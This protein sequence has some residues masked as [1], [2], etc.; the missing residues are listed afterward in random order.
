M[1]FHKE[2]QTEGD[3]EKGALNWSI[4]GLGW[5]EGVNT[6]CEILEGS[7]QNPADE[8][9]QNAEEEMI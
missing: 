1:G 2:R 5:Q 7:N 6:G 9:T 3:A 8:G 4:D